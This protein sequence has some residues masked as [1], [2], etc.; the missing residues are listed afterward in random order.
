M[1]EYSAEENFFSENFQLSELQL[2]QKRLQRLPQKMT[3]AR[4][5]ECNKKIKK[6]L[7]AVVFK[8]EDRP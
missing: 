2:P 5:S 3:P 1:N 8:K 4:C 6:E 7:M